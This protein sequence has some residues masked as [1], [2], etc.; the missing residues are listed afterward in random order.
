M[1]AGKENEAPA[2]PSTAVAARRI[3]LAARRCGL[4]KRAGG[5]RWPCRV[6]LRDITNLVAAGAV[7]AKLEVLPGLQDP[8]QVAKLH[9]MLPPSTP[10]KAAR[11]SLRKGFR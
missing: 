7:A 9:P 2:A 3:G 11:Y 5:T 8:D 4:K 6:P 10:A 1:A